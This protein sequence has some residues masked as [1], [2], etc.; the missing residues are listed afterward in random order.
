MAQIGRTGHANYPFKGKMRVDPVKTCTG[1]LFCL[2][3]G[4]QPPKGRR[5]PA[6]QGPLD[7]ANMRRGVEVVENEGHETW[8]K[9]WSG[10]YG[11]GVSGGMGNE[12]GQVGRVKHRD[13]G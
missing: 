7:G 11:D 4:L 6:K 8:A 5:R 9:T 3:P 1:M 2:C 12:I 13:D 10:T